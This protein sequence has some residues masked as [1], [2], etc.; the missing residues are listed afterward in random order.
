MA[1]V[2]QPREQMLGRFGRAFPECGELVAH[3]HD[4][5]LR[6]HRISGAVDLALVADNPALKANV[7]ENLPTDRKCVGS[8]VEF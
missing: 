5:D 2:L 7:F 8:A 6:Q 1:P 4:L 3:G